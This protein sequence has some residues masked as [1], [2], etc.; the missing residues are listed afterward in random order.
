MEGLKDCDYVL[1]PVPMNTFV[2]QYRGAGYEGKFIGTE[3]HLAFMSMVDAADQWDELDGMLFIKPNGW[4]NDEGEIIELT[5]ELLYDN[6][7]A[8]ADEIMRSGCGYQAVYGVYAILELVADTVEE[9]GAHNFSSQALYE[10]A[11]SF[12]MEVEGCSFS[13]DEDKGL[14]PIIWLFM[15]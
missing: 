12:S 7:P 14:P 10:N 4:W 9:V 8:D 13:F 1:L 3:A 11:M 6:H 2:E 5:K 15:N